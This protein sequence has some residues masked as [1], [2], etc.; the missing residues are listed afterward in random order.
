MKYYE[1][2]YEEYIQSVQAENIHPEL[3]G[4]F[5]TFPATIAQMGN[6]ILYGSSGSGKYSQLLYLLQRYSPSRLKYDKKIRV[7]TEKQSYVY[8]I[9]DI[10]YEIDMGLLGC[11]SK[12]IW[13]EAFFQIVD[14]ISMKPDKVGIIVCKNFHMIHSELLEVFYSYI[15]H[16][17]AMNHTIHIRFILMTEHISFIP[18]N[19]LNCCEKLAVRKPADELYAKMV[20]TNHKLIQQQSTQN[21]SVP[22]EMNVGF[23]NRISN[24]RK[25]VPEK[26]LSNIFHLLDTTSK[27]SILNLKEIQS[28][29]VVKSADDLPDDIFNIIC[30]NIIRDISNPNTLEFAN[31]RENLYDILIYNLD[32]TDCL[33]YIL[34]HFI[35]TGVL[36]DTSDILHHTYTFLKYYNNNYRPIYHLESIFFYLILQIQKCADE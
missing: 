11:H 13:H 8:R 1:T 23:I 2:H 28:F 33:W 30:N 26:Q 29:S 5:E 34:Y 16:S 3:S 36:T 35:H 14:I 31:F 4:L 12:T 7:Q 6:L 24:H 20:R 21:E 22:A 10:H 25:P 9:S 27:E 32:I 17:S 18:N 15:Q 19:I